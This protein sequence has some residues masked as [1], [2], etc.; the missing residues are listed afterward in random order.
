ME[1]KAALQEELGWM[2][3][4]KQAMICLPTGL[5]EA[6]GGALFEAVLPGLL[7]L[8]IGI[9][10][11]GRGNKKYGD[12]VSKLS[13]DSSHR[14]AVIQDDEDEVRKMFAG[15][16]M[17]LFFSENDDEVLRASLRYGCVPIA[18]SSDLLENYAPAQE[19]GNAFVYEEMNQ[20]QCFASI[21]RALETFKFPY[22]WRTIQ[23]HAI[24]CM[25]RREELVGA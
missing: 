1:N 22:D 17:A 18:F 10:V 4:P 7:E 11:L 3:E 24:E 2:D 23:R 6:Q 16:D 8:P 21:V 13:K 25:E 15:S 19:S 14:I 20:W 9:V 5:T 12:I